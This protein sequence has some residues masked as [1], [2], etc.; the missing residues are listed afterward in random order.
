[1]MVVDDEL[2]EM[3]NQGAS[4]VAL[5]KKAQERG[6]R[7]LWEDGREKVLRGITTFEEVARVCEEQVELKPVKVEVKPHVTVKEEIMKVKKPQEVKVDT[8]ALEEYRR[9]I[10]RWLSGKR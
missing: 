6:M 3:I 2:R 7:L 9:R 4:T 5:R 10:A 8:H 1:L